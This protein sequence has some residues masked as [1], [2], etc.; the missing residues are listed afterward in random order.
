MKK[1]IEARSDAPVSADDHNHTADNNIIGQNIH[2][3]PKEH[4]LKTPH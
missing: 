4:A 3:K 2:S 1:E